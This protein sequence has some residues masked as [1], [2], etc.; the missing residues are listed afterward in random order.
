MTLA[1][2]STI[3]TGV[4]VYRSGLLREMPFQMRLLQSYPFER[5]KVVFIENFY[6]DIH[7][8]L[9]IFFD[10]FDLPET[11]ESLNYHD[12]LTKFDKIIEYQN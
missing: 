4:I 2:V 11:I 6:L 12:M 10:Y 5:E 1:A 7:L 9:N 3:T 8:D